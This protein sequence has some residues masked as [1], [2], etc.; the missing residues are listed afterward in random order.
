M[1]EQAKKRI[2]IFGIVALMLSNFS[3]MADVVVIPAY[4][5]I[6]SNFSNSPSFVTNFIASGS[7]IVL[8][9]GSLTAPILMRHF[10]KKSIILVGFG[11]FTIVATCTGLINDAIYVAV[12]RGITGYFMGLVMPTA[13]ALIIEIYKD[14]DKLRS[15]YIGWIDG[16]MAGIG[17]IMMVISGALLT[18]GWQTIFFEY[19]IGVPIWAMMLIFLPH[20][21]ANKDRD[22][23]RVKGNIGEEEGIENAISATATAVAN[24]STPKSFNKK[25]LVALIVSF[26]ACN[27]FYGAIMYEYSIYLAENFVIPSYLNGMLGAIKGVLGALMG[28]VV[29]APLFARAKRFTITIC[30]CAQAV[31]YFGLMFVLEGAAG[32]AWFLICYS[33]IGVAFGLSVPF[34]YSYASMK[35]PERSMSLVTSLLSVAFAVGSFLST[36]FVTLIQSLIGVQT[37]T[38]VIPYIGIC[39]LI[40]AALTVVAGLKDK[41]SKEAFKNL[42]KDSKR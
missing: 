20:T 11:T 25:T 14:D 2:S 3:Y 19:L 24:A 9:I 38:P 8:I 15:K 31:A 21:P 1:T 33:F 12:M 26:V 22:N 36:Y 16:S 4:A 23:K 42:V 5:E 13:M 41:S 34:Y 27:L 39:C 28:F 6:F 40:A 18:F 10:S 37:Y 35:F 17:A 7:Q 29:F 30:F 32:I